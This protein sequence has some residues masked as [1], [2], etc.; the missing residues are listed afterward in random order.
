VG[1]EI[2]LF[3]LQTMHLVKPFD[4]VRTGIQTGKTGVGAQPKPI[5]PIRLDSID[6]LSRDAPEP[7]L[8]FKSHRTR[9]GGTA[10][11]AIE[12]AARRAHPQLAVVIQVQRVH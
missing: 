8:I 3:I 7:R 11:H 4:R 1:V 2:E 9:L 10:D 5:L 12:A 6:D